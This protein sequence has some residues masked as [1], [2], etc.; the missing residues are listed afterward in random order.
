MEVKKLTGGPRFCRTCRGARVQDLVFG[1]G[2]EVLISQGTVYKP[3]R[4]HHCRKCKKC[5]LKMDHHCAL[6]CCVPARL[7]GGGE[8][9]NILQV[10]G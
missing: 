1:D 4:A 5:V 2:R 6:S 3:P 9:T 10:L 7:R 8:L